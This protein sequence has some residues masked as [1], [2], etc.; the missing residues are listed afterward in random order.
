MSHVYFHFKIK[1]FSYNEFLHIFENVEG[2]YDGM[3]H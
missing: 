3:V 2:V 1:Y